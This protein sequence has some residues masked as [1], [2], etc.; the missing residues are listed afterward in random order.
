MRGD[1][2]RGLRP[3][4]RV[5]TW[6][7]G[8]LSLTLGVGAGT[9]L[10]RALNGLPLELHV[11]ELRALVR[12]TLFCPMFPKFVT[13]GRTLTGLVACALFGLAVTDVGTIAVSIA[14]MAILA[15]IA[16]YLPTG[17]AARVD[18]VV[19]LRYE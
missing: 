4:A 3:L 7:T 2:R 16:G 6:T 10:N 11:L 13:P 5:K 1:L 17:R 9:A 18:P 14:F 19:A 12:A 15:P 8:V